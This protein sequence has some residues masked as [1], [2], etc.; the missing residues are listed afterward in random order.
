MTGP[1]EKPDLTPERA[2]ASLAVHEQM[3]EQDDQQGRTAARPWLQD[4]QGRPVLDAVAFA[5]DWHGDLAWAERCLD[6]LASGGVRLLLHVGDFG[7]WPGPGGRKYLYR[8]ER[9]CAELGITI[10]VTPGNHEDWDRLDSRT[11]A[12]RGDG[13]GPVIDL[14]G[15]HG[16]DGHVVVFPRGARFSIRT[17]SGSERSFVSLGGAPSI[18][19]EYRTRGRDW[20]GSEMIEPWH[21]EQVV[22]GGYADVMV[23]HDAPGPPYAV[24]AV[25]AILRS[26]PM[27]WSDQALAYAAVGRKR[28]TQAFEGVRPKVLVHGHY[29]A[30]GTAVVPLFE[31]SVIDMADRPGGKYVGPEIAGAQTGE[32]RVVSLADQRNAENLVV[33]DLESFQRS[34]PAALYAPGR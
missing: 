28:V 27:G 5:G 17:P 10:A 23:T 14:T 34:V 31:G 9:T 22:A 32:C 29:H 4:V 19:F 30:P 26:N 8:L 21:V 16:N 12:D 24:P 6:Y 15:S 11:P 7:I 2:A 18:D 1:A 20:W 33:L 25:E 3:H 13:L